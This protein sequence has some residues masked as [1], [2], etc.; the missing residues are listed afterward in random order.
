MATKVELNRPGLAK[1]RKLAGLGVGKDFA[2]RINVDPA[3][4]SRVLSGKASP[5]SA[6][7]GGCVEAF[8]AEYFEDIFIVERDDAA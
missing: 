5:S 2:E 1:V 8:G 6:F 7:I 4:V 3:T